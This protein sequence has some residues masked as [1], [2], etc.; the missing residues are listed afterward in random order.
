MIKNY[1]M[2]EPKEFSIQML[3]PLRSLFQTGIQCSLHCPRASTCLQGSVE[4]YQ[5]TFE[6]CWQKLPF[7]D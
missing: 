3:C 6:M 1:N 2:S 5:L 4:H 7:P